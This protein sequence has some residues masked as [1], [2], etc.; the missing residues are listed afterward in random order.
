MGKGCEVHLADL[1]WLE[2]RKE[3]SSPLCLFSAFHMEQRKRSWI[4]CLFTEGQSESGAKEK[5]NN[6]DGGSTESESSEAAVCN[7]FQV[8]TRS[9]N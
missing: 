2:K 5:K 6:K 9:D 7:A 4:Y 3:K 1:N 8:E